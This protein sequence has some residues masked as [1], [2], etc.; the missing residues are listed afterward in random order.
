MSTDKTKKIKFSKYR[1]LRKTHLLI[2]CIALMILLSAAYIIGQFFIEWENFNEVANTVIIIVG[3]VAFW[4]EFKNNGYLNESQFIMELNNQF[5]SN[6]D[7]IDVES[8]LEKCY[9]AFHNKDFD[10][11]NKELANFETYL[12]QNGNRQHLVNY[13][14][15][16]EGIA[17]II[18]NGVLHLD[19]ID[20][21][22]A[23][24]YFIA[25]NN[26]VVQKMEL[27]EYANFF[28][29]CFNVYQRW[30]KVLKKQKS[31]IPMIENDL[32]VAYQKFK[33]NKEHQKTH[34]NTQ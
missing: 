22:M 26:P 11:Y 17:A 18:N 16:L 25:V 7:L 3:A 1:S 15:H 33:D 27:L 20:D 28:Q 34:A 8:Q 29:G 23:Y 5:I 32:I 21:L 6:S 30:K 12:T 10:L 14:V 2:I 4:L 24:R 19:V 31:E 13:L 9:C